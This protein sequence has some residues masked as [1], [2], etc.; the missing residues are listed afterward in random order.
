MWL[1]AANDTTPSDS[2]EWTSRTRHDDPFVETAR[3]KFF[4]LYMLHFI[5]CTWFPERSSTQHIR[6]E[7][8]LE[9]CKRPTRPDARSFTGRQRSLP[10]ERHLP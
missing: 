3:F 2:R 7:G 9:P 10:A 4:S 5:V 6:T 8:Q 1:P